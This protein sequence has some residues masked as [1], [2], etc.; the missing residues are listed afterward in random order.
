MRRLQRGRW[1]SPSR[2]EGVGK[3]ER[4]ERRRGEWKRGTE[5]N[6]R[7]TVF[8]LLAV[9]G[10]Y[11]CIKFMHTNFACPAFALVKRGFKLRHYNLAPF[12]DYFLYCF[13][14]C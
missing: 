14:L 12:S 13:C 5:V 2:R 11:F 6:G 9:A 7:E 8:Q 1:D 4:R 10:R 3:R